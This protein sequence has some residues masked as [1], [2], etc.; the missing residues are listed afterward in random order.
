[1]KTYQMTLHNVVNADTVMKPFETHD[2]VVNALFTAAAE[3]SKRENC[4]INIVED[5]TDMATADL[6]SSEY[7]EL[8][9]IIS[10]K[11]ITP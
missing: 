5:S 6:I 1:M 10:V 11:E 3:I 4:K 2:T 9:Y 8:L 7:G